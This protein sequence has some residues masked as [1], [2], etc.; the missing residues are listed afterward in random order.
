MIATSNLN[1]LL[2][3]KGRLAVLSVVTGS[4]YNPATSAHSETTVPYPVKAYFAEYNLGEAS[5]EVSSGKRWV[6]IGTT[7]TS[8]VTFPKPNAKDSIAGAEDS[9]II[10]KVQVI[11][12]GETPVCYLCTVLE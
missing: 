1:F 11:Y 2:Q 6:L 7:D 12:N 3:R 4:T 5:S 8:G 10:S 9:V